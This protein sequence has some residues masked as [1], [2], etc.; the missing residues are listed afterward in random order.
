MVAGRTATPILAGGWASFEI[1]SVLDH[2]VV[3]IDLPRTTQILYP[4]DIGFIFVTLGI[5]PGKKVIEA[6]TGSGSMTIALAYTVGE[7]GRVVSY[8]VKPDVQNLARKN[9]MRFGLES[10]V[11]FK[12]RDIN[13]GF[14]ETDADVVVTDVRMPPGFSDEGLPANRRASLALE[15]PLTFRLRR[16]QLPD[17]LPP[18]WQVHEVDRHTLEVTVPAGPME[19]MLPE[20]RQ[21]QVRTAGQLPTGFEPSLFYRSVHHPRGLS[22]TIFAAS[23]CLGDSGLEWD[24]LRDRG[25]LA[26][27]SF[28]SLEDRRVKRFITD[29]A[30]GC[31]CPP[32]LPVC[33]CDREPEAEPLS[34][35]PLAPT[36]EEM[37]RNPRSHSARLRGARKLPRG[38]GA[39]DEGDRT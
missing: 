2:E 5:G 6:G 23:D 32:E 9:L 4:K 29:R 13:E 15:S 38:L 18:T 34:R 20:T 16:R 3:V 10:R 25:R 28:H 22:M 7:D 36:P 31:V 11:D 27:I 21:A 26:V 33:V 8:E 39:D 35:R 37:E 1:E 19:V 12:L 30:R 17:D 14:D 24:L